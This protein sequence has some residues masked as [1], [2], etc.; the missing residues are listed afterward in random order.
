MKS[1]ILAAVL[2]AVTGSAMAEKGGFESG[3]KAPPAHKQDAGYKGTE[4]TTESQVK[5]LR[6][7]KEGSW[8]TLEGNIVEKHS[9]DRY[10]FRDKSGSLPVT[11]DH[12]VWK[13]RTYNASDLVRI[14]GRTEGQGKNT[15]LKVERLDEP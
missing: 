11:I 4:D 9:G 10:T 8:V 12:K 1:V 7:L 13:E 3:E 5:T 2:L 14:S 15:A 6:D